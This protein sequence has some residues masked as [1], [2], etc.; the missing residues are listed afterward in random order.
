MGRSIFRKGGDFTAA[1]VFQF[2]AT[3]LVIELGVLLA[4]IVGW[5][6]TLTEFVGG[7]LMI[8]FTVLLFRGFLKPRVVAAARS[9]AEK[10]L[11]GAMEGHSEMAAMAKLG[12]VWRRV[13][14]KEGLTAISHYF[15]MNWQLLWK[16][17]VGGLLI[18]GSLG[19]LVP[20][21][22]WP[23]LFFSGHG[24]LSAAWS[25]LVGPIVAIPSFVCSNGNVPSR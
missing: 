15:V 10:G 19:A 7:P 12:A 4:I 1:M 21:D 18:A 25:V 14:S 23:L 9:Q 16:N 11:G 17:I 22:F 20:H 2:A 6:F 3:N 24:L 8:A 5:Q 13:F